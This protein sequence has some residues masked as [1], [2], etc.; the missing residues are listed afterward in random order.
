M[1]CVELVLATYPY[2]IS[3]FNSQNILKSSEEVYVIYIVYSIV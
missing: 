2:P 1:C 3:F